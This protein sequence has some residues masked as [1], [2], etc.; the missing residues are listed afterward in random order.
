[1]VLPVMLIAMRRGVSIRTWISAGCVLVGII[2]AIGPTFKAS[3]IEGLAVMG[4]GCV[5]IVIGNLIEVAPIGRREKETVDE[6]EAA[7]DPGGN[8]AVEQAH[9]TDPASGTLSRIRKPM[10]R[11]FVLFAILLA[12]YLL[13]ALPFKVIEVIPG[14]A[15]PLIIMM[16]EE[17]GFKPLGPKGTAARR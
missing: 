15:I 7:M 6:P 9:V 2:A 10:V 14:F 4:I 8:G 17:F 16:Q 12:V 11:K 3:D 5:L 1:V 13:M